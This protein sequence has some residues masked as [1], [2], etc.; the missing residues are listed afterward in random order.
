MFHLNIKAN[1]DLET[2]TKILLFFYFSNGKYFVQNI[3]NNF[4]VKNN[5]SY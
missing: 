2:I 1:K 4:E 5:I 3:M